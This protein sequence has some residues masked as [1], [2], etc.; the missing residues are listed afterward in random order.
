MWLSF[1]RACCGAALLFTL[2]GFAEPVK[3]V[4]LIRHAEKGITEGHS[5][6]PQLTECGQQRA[7]ALAGFFK[8]VPLQAIYS[9]DY[10]RTLHTAAPIA[11]AQ[12]LEVRQYDPNQLEQFAQTLQQQPEQN[13][14][15]VGH[16]NTTPTLAKHL[17]GRPVAALT[18]ADFDRL[19]QVLLTPAQ[20]QLNV[21]RQT[22][23]CAG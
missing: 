1:V 21:F 17:T 20:P 5:R 15:V 11:S 12:Q 22:F 13:I 16:S 10:Q 23:R 7:Q 8:S 4:Y 9:T 2:P 18:E 3:S 14:L 6:D 19:Y